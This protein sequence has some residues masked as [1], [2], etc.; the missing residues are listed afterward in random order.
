MSEFPLIDNALRA[1]Q[2]GLDGLSMRQ[3]AIGRNLANVDTPGYQAQTVN[4]ESVIRRVIKGSSTLPMQASNINHL[5]AASSSSHFMTTARPGGTERAD[6][7]NVDIDIELSSQTETGIQYQAL[8]QMVSK[9]L[10]LLKTLSA[11]R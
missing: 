3:Q 7:N 11:S 10:T 6:Q 2:M 5:S 4:F 9:K 1:A 8:A